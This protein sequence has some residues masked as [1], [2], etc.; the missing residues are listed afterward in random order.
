MTKPI[1]E[2]RLRTELVA[3]ARLVDNRDDEAIYTEEDTPIQNS[4]ML[5]WQLRQQLWC[6]GASSAEIEQF[7]LDLK[8]H[9]SATLRTRIVL[10]SLMVC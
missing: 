7:I 2:R 4:V 10:T 8:E 3:S 6:S 1:N 5:L 9:K